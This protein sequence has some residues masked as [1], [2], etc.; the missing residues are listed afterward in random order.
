[1]GDVAVVEAVLNE[2]GL[3]GKAILAGTQDPAVK[4]KL[5]D[6]TESAAKRGGFWYSRLLC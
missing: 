3:D 6:N 5:I 2:A 4:Q 1:M